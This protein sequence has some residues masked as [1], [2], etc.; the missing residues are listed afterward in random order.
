MVLIFFVSFVFIVQTQMDLHHPLPHH[1]S[2]WCSFYN[3]QQPCNVDQLCAVQN[4]VEQVCAVQNDVEQLCAAQQHV[5]LCNV[6]QTEQLLQKKF[7]KPKL[8]TIFLSVFLLCLFLYCLRFLV[9]KIVNKAAFP[10]ASTLPNDETQV[11]K[12]FHYDVDRHV[13]FKQNV[14]S[15][16]TLVF[17]K[18]NGSTAES[19]VLDLWDYLVHFEGT[20]IVPEYPGYGQRVAETRSHVKPVHELKQL[21]Q[22]IDASQSLTLIAYSIGT[23]VL[24]EALY[25]LQC[26]QTKIQ[27]FLISPFTTTWDV[28]CRLLGFPHS[29]SK[30][31]RWFRH[32]SPVERLMK[33][34]I[35]HP[36]SKITVLHGERD[37][38]IPSEMSAPL[39]CIST[40][41]VLPHADHTHPDLFSTATSWL[42]EHFKHS[43]PV[44][45]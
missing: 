20:V 21:L 13:L 23:G 3:S 44:E 14:Q 41:I 27:I 16:H 5:Q 30:V 31:S 39:S 26:P 24:T 18:G 25:Q 42:Q 8:L 45:K 2:P 29:F 37:R 4:D 33:W 34:K 7:K 19:A 17:L 32:Y 38:L 12:E 22:Q 36:H 10:G 15:K 11:Y 28:A 35:K 1:H 40:R 9:Y 6:D 43:D